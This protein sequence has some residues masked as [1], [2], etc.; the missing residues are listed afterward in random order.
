MGLLLGVHNSKMSKCPEHLSNRKADIHTF[1]LWLAKLDNVLEIYVR[2]SRSPTSFKYAYLHKESD[3]DL[4]VLTRNPIVVPHARRHFK[5]C[6]DVGY[7][8]LAVFNREHRGFDKA[9]I[10][11]YPEDPHNIFVE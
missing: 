7:Q 10:Q 3:W 1:V 2:G 4:L 9:V 6:A 5:L 11:V 8:T